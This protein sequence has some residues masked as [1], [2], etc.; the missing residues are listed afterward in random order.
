[1]GEEAC[2]LSEAAAQLHLEAK[3]IWCARHQL[4]LQLPVAL[5]PAPS[6]KLQRLVSLC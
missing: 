5:L 1:M 2:W 6:A 3:V 4:L